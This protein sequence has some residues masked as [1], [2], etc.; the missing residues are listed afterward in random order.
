MPKKP[1]NETDLLPP[2]DY[3]GKDGWDSKLRQLLTE[4]TVPLPPPSTELEV[5]RC[6]ARIGFPLPSSLKLFL[7]TFGPVDFDGLRI[8][9]PEDVK[10]LQNVWF[11]DFLA[12]EEQLKLA[13]LI[14]VAETGS[15]NYYAL[16]ASD[17][18]CCL[19][20]HDPSGLFDW[21]SSF[22]DL[23]KMAVIDLSWGYY[24]WLDSEIEEMARHL[25][26]ELLGSLPNSA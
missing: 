12:R 17:G 19:C 22:D 26:R 14:Q 8:C 9:P 3:I 13:G 20:S 1:E 4:Y 24:G 15:D 7:L 23:I 25:K 5:Q 6:E 10:T 21:L 18:R 11:R 2:F 16:D